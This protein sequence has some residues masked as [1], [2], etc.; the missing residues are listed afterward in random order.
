MKL[1][2]EIDAVDR[3]SGR[4][5]LRDRDWRL[6]AAALLVAAAYYLGAKIGLALT[7]SPYPISVLWP[8]NAVLLAALLLAPVRW[9]ALLL[10]AAF[11]A[12]LI[13][14][15]QGGVPT[16]MV[17]CWFLSNVSEA[18]IGA[19]CVRR[20][21]R[22]PLALDNVHNLVIFF[23]SAVLLAPFLSSFMDAAFVTYIGW[24]EVGYW[25]LW[26]TRFVSNVLATLTFVPVIVTWAMLDVPWMRSVKL[27]RSVE[28]AV[29]SCGLLAAGIVVFN[30]QTAAS[31]LPNTLIYLPLP[32]LLWTALRFGVYGTSAAFMA[33][34]LLAIWGA[35]HGRGPFSGTSPAETA[36]SV[37]LFLISVAIP[38]LF[39]AAVMEERR[40]TSMNSELCA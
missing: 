5:G 29:L 8:P 38:M 18:L 32:F 3:L 28:G 24:G 7:F 9:W 12:H 17:F 39:L 6:A 36:L 16:A 31:G 27:A 30:W 33:I 11:P 10:L 23:A 4:A 2:H 22:G 13:A 21:V 35:G 15:L 20:F 37:Q 40:N 25:Q 19:V 14:Q 1:V 26:K 34:A